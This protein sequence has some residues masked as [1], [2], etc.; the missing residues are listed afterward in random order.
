MTTE[1]E[2]E[3]VAYGVQFRTASISL[4][5]IS[6]AVDIASA[7]GWRRPLLAWLGNKFPKHR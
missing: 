5:G 3:L 1:T 7:Q 4:Q 6:A 2:T